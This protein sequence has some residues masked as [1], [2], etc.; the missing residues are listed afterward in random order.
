[1]GNRLHVAKR[2]IVEYDSY[3]RFNWQANESHDFLNAIGIEIC[4]SDRTTDPCPW[5]FEISKEDWKE[6]IARL[7]E[8]PMT[9]EVKETLKALRIDKDE[10][11]EIGECYLKVADPNHD[12]LEFSFF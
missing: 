8:E 5:D 7:K 3:A 4:G 10:M 11:A 12:Y 1:M 6:G 2:Y 9:D